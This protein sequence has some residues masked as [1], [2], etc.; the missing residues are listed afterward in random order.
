MELAKPTPPEI[1]KEQDTA[2]PPTQAALIATSALYGPGDFRRYNPDDL[3]GR[4]GFRIYKQMSRDEQ[5]KAAS[6]FRRNAVTSRGWKLTYPEDALPA[7]EAIS[8][9]AV[10]E[11][12]IANIPGSFRAKLNYIMLALTQGFSITEKEYGPVVFNGSP[13]W[14]IKSMR[15]KPFETFYFDTDEFG[16]LKGIRQVAGSG[17]R[18]KVDPKRVIHYVINPEIDE[19][20]GQSE[21]R[22]AYRSYYSKD[23]LIKLENIYLERMAGGLV[24][25]GQ[26]EGTT[27]NLSNNARAELQAVLSNIQTMTGIMMPKDWDLNIETPTSTDAFERAI[28][29]HDR[30]IAKALLMPNL[31]GLTESG[32]TGSYSQSQTQME[33]FLWMLDSD[34]ADLAECVQEQLIKDLCDVNWGDGIYPLFEFNPLSDTQKHGVLTLWK[35]LVAAKVVTPSDTDEAYVRDLMGFPEKAEDADEE[36][37]EGDPPDGEGEVEPPD[38]NDPA[39][40]DP[41]NPQNQPPGQDPQQQ[42]AGAA[43]HEHT[44]ENHGGGTDIVYKKAFSIAQRRVDFTAID[45]SSTTAEHTAEQGLGD[46]MLSLAQHFADTVEN[47]DGILEQP[48]VGNKVKV[49]ASYRA[50]IKKLGKKLLTDSWAIGAQNGKRELEKAGLRRMSK[51]EFSKFASIGDIATR[52]F[53]AKAF[54]M[55]GKLTEDALAIFKQQLLSGI[56]YSKSKEQTIQDIYKAFATAGL[57]TEDQVI[58]ALGQAVQLENPGARLRTV[59]RTNTFDAINEA[60]YNYF[61]DAELGG[62]VSALQYSAILDSRTT[63][64]CTALDDVAM[65]SDRWEE[66]RPPNHFNCR[67]LLVPVTTRDTDVT[68]SDGPPQEVADGTVQPAEG[69][70]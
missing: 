36:G 47:T 33:G 48:Q 39:Q 56:K 28:N 44:L 65:R 61:T 62:F 49:P 43:G 59:V 70:R 37:A 8:R 52:Y 25:A 45:R 55:A 18:I 63:A 23:V 13:W 66:L 9:T 1:P 3:I 4:R 41:N 40:Q 19:F 14:G 57:L 22:E 10:L 26:R 5:V 12:I 29:R 58:E 7:E 69:F 34:A 60:R 16:E 53:E 21:L 38:P 31:L 35:D 50:D 27:G 6:K 32:Q 2:A 46:V 20:Y 67:S 30:N 15:K 11:Y 64:I 24:W 68:I 17:T 42:S 51:E 54:Q